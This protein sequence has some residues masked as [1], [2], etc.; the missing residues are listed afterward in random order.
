MNYATQS[1]DTAIITIYP[2]E[3]DDIRNTIKRKLYE[4]ITTCSKNGYIVSIDTIYFSTM[5]NKISRTTGNCIVTISY[6]VTT[7]KPQQ[8]HVYTATVQQIYKD[9]LFT[10]FNGIRILTPSSSMME[11]VYHDN[12]FVNGDNIISIGDLVDIHIEVTRYDNGKYQCIGTLL[13]ET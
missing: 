4:T 11:W 7:L 5:T 8:G 2:F 10:E 1:T 6:L 9:G 13:S 12:A 3:L